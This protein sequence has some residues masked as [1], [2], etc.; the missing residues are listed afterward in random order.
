MTLVYINGG[1]VGGS[2]YNVQLAGV[3][4]QKLVFPKKSNLTGES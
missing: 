3:I 1:A 2:S 4:V